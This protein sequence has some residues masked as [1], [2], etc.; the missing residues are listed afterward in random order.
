MQGGQRSVFAYSIAVQWL[1]C[2]WAWGTGAFPGTPSQ[3]Q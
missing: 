2:G 1:G 3:V